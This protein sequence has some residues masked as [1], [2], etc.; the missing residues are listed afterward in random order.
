MVDP[1]NLPSFT[2]AVSMLESYIANCKVSFNK[3]KPGRTTLGKL[4]DLERDYSHLIKDFLLA[5]NLGMHY[6]RLAQDKCHTEQTLRELNQDLEAKCA[7]KAARYS[8]V[9]AKLADASQELRVSAETALEVAKEKEAVV[10]LYGEIEE[11]QQ[12]ARLEAVAGFEAGLKVKVFG[13]TEGSLEELASLAKKK[14]EQMKKTVLSLE[15]RRRDTEQDLARATKEIEAL[16]ELTATQGKQ[17]E[18]STRELDKHRK[19]AKKAVASRAKGSED[20]RLIN[21]QL[22]KDN[23]ALSCE[24][25]RVVDQGKVTSEELMRQVVEAEELKSNSRLQSQEIAALTQVVQTLQDECE[26]IR[27]LATARAREIRGLKRD[28]E[29]MT[30]ETD[31]LRAELHSAAQEMQRLKEQH[32]EITEEAAKV[33]ESAELQTEELEELRLTVSDKAAELTKRSLEIAELKDA[34]LRQTDELA[35]LL[36][37]RRDIEQLTEEASELKGQLLASAQES[38]CLKEHNAEITTEVAWLKET[39][40]HLTSQLEEL[41][42]SM[43]DNAAEVTRRSQEIAELKD[44]KLRQTKDTEQVT[45]ETNELKA[46]LLTASQETQ[47]L[48]E[49]NAEITGEVARLKETEVYLTSQ[50]EDLRSLISDNSAELTRRNLEIA[51]LEDSKQLHIDEVEGLL[52]EMD[53]LALTCKGQQEELDRLHNIKRSLQ[54]VKAEDLH[55]PPC[56]KSSQGSQTCKA[57][58]SCES[59]QIH[60]SVLPPRLSQSTSTVVMMSIARID[61]VSIKP[62]VAPISMQCIQHVHILPTVKPP[63]QVSL[64]NSIQIKPPLKV[65]CASQTTHS[66]SVSSGLSTEIVETAASYLPSVPASLLSVHSMTVFC[67]QPRL[68][69]LGLSSYQVHVSPV[70]RPHF[71]MPSSP[72]EAPYS[73][74]LRVSSAPDTPLGRRNTRRIFTRKEP[75]QEFFILVSLTQTYQSIK[76]ND[77]NRDHLNYIPVEELYDSAIAQ[78]IPFNQVKV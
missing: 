21:E 67:S 64:A 16:K 78:A 54:L 56:L 28:F 50:L 37:L 27:D 73:D 18:R 35:D 57:E 71:A 4:Q 9:V 42:L 30:Q 23:E 13:E 5:A 2:E 31:G 63:L 36:I 25:A 65:P 51:A 1:S 3:D 33:K 12:Q 77:S 61:V 52:I 41:R 44:S 29:Q 39:E 15:K 55:L 24:I 74:D 46:E 76:L 14:T 11:L 60:C 66:L 43:S 48:N 58:L 34:Q 10:R 69:S 70:R 75:M 62:H 19:D 49:H 45:Q 40:V 38:Q 32:A 7:E 8:E 59:I 68:F 53:E 20:L 47:R 17:L 22:L 72:Q 26:E 6:V